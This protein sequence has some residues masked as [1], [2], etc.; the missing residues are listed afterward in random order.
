MVQWLRLHASSDS[1]GTPEGQQ[2]GKGHSHAASG[3]LDKKDG[4]KRN[5]PGRLLALASTITCTG[6]T[7]KVLPYCLFK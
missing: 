5:Y 2:D 4:A 6:H 7:Q 1:L 3:S